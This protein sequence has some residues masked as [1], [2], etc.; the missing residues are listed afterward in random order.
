MAKKMSDIYFGLTKML[1]REASEPMG[2][3][4]TLRSTPGKPSLRKKMLGKIK[5]RISTVKESVRKVKIRF[6]KLEATLKL[7]RHKIYKFT[8]NIK[9][10]MQ[11]GSYSV[12]TARHGEDLE[13]CLRLRYE[14]F[15]REYRHKKRTFG[16]DIDKL[17]FTCDHLMIEDIKTGQVVG[18]YRLNS[19]QFNSKFYSEGEFRMQEVLDLPGHKLELGRACIDKDHRTGIVIALLWRG[20]SDYMRLTDS[21]TLFGCASVKTVKP[22]EIVSVARW[23]A[24]RGHFNLDLKIRPRTKY[25]LR[26]FTRLKK[27][28]ERHPSAYDEM[29]AGELVPNLVMAYFKAGA[30]LVGEPAVDKEFNCIDFLL[31]LELGKMSSA[32]AKKYR[33]E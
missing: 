11:R 1:R 9:I 6:E 24:D 19:S 25:R 10:E 3:K 8:P 12:R 2:M 13:K 30:K 14:V 5:S 16:V 15:H 32:Y 28:L 29:A 27:K 17:D 4:K 22:L 26:G 18:T 23:L 21:E 20:I 33:S 31:I 7:H